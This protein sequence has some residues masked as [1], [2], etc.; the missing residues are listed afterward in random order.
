MLVET[1]KRVRREHGHGW[2]WLFH[3]Q[4]GDL[5]H[6]CSLAAAF[7]LHH[8]VHLPMRLV[9]R[10]HLQLGV[11]ELFR[12]QFETIIVE[13][14]LAA[15]A[16]DWKAF[17]DELNLG[18]FSPETPIVLHPH[19]NPEI[20]ELDPMLFENRLTW[21][22]LYKHVLRLPADVEPIPPPRRA[23]LAQEALALC[24]Q[25][26][27]APG[28]STILFPY[29]RSMNVSALQH[30]EALGKQFEQ[31][32]RTVF[33]SVAGAE[34]PV[35][36]T[37][38]IFIPFQLLIDVAEHAGW[39]VAV[40]SGIDDVL[41]SARCRKTSVYPNMDMVRLWDLGGMGLCRD[42]QQI[43]F[44]FSTRTPADFCACVLSGPWD[45]GALRPRTLSD[46]LEDAIGRENFTTFSF[47]DLQR[48]ASFVNRTAGEIAARL[49]PK[50]RLPFAR[51]V[52]GE[53]SVIRL[54][55]IP[56][57][58]HPRWG[59]FISQALRTL[60][61]DADGRD[62]RFYACRDSIGRDFLE[63]LDRPGLLQ[64][65]YVAARYDH[66]LLVVR[67]DPLERLPSR[68]GKRVLK[69]ERLPQAVQIDTSGRHGMSAITRYIDTNRPMSCDGL[70]LIDG[71]FEPEP[72]G[73][74]TK[75]L[76]TTFKL[77]FETRPQ[78]GFRVVLN[79]GV[80]L[81]PSFPRLNVLVRVNGVCVGGEAL[82]AGLSPAELTISVPQ[83]VATGAEVF[84][85]E[86]AFAEIYSPAQQGAGD[87]RRALGLGVVSV[88][89]DPTRRSEPA[90]T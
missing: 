14:G 69:I 25:N 40:R 59:E 86:L 89:I 58:G 2:Y 51:R 68:I 6:G 32:G 34:T 76:R 15:L 66:T 61:G 37:R 52:R 81:S 13:P 27:V 73:I 71:W 83:A 63:E 65:L 87:D 54:T 80:A 31:R 33:T 22:Q 57:R 39:T 23:D 17:R 79:C 50:G 20:Y 47:V 16:D 56:P 3:Q 53:R 42:A 43:A 75:G 1:W 5:Y 41:S 74:W 48:D 82:V 11:A 72:F 70:Q 21:M 18:P 78:D 60:F 19:C 12:D 62:L 7:R 38:P 45:S 35:P 49:R 67:G 46:E 29:A 4:N 84:W 55:D 64:G 36:G 44:D 28:R 85:I 26:G 30:M 10:S 88:R 77:A 9:V 90:T 8:A 24:A